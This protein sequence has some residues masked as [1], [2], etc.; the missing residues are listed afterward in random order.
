LYKHDG[1][2]ILMWKNERPKTTRK[3]NMLHC[4]SY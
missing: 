2:K 1:D 4:V 3:D